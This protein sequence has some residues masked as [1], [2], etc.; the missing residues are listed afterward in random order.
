MLYKNR[1]GEEID[2]TLERIANKIV[3]G[4]MEAPALLFFE[5]IRPVSF[6]GFRL[7]GAFLAPLIPF[8]GYSVD[9][10]I[11]PF[12]ERENVEKVIKLIELK[13][14]ERDEKEKERKRKTKLIKVK[15]KKP[16]YWP[17]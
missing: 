14:K 2:D 7:G 12:R 9:D 10:F 17:F 3:E 4:K 5:S 15:K 8:I 1:T 11:V 6:I 16:W 13:A